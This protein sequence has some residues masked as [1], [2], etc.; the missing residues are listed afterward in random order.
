MDPIDKHFKSLIKN[1]K[2]DNTIDVNLH[3]GEIKAIIDCLT[4]AYT[5][6]RVLSE[7]ELKKGSTLGMREMSRIQRDAKELS[8]IL[9]KHMD[10]GQPDQKDIN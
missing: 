9:A 2:D 10:I 5:A 7:V 1:I 6:A 3:A 4:F 8:L